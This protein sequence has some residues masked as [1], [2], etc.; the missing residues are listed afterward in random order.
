M[1]PVIPWGLSNRSQRPFESPYGAPVGVNP[2]RP[3]STRYEGHDD[4]TVSAPLDPRSLR[5]FGDFGVDR[6]RSADSAVVRASRAHHAVTYRRWH[7]S[8]Q[9]RGHLPAIAGV[10]TGRR[11]RQSD[12]DPADP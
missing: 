12:G 10:R 7:A 6:N 5:N 11:R 3:T 8:L 2:T 1:V 4:A 9:R